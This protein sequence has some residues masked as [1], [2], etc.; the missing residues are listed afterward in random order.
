MN[1]SLA[2]IETISIPKGIEAGDA[3]M[4]ASAVD[5][6]AA[7]TVC[8]GKFIVIVTGDVAAVKASMEAGAE[9]AGQ[10]L[11]DSM[12]IPNIDPQVPLAINCCT[13]PHREDSIGILE[14]FSL[15]AAVLMA[16]TAVK[17]ADVHLTEV[18]L[19]RGLG[20]KSFVIFTGDVAAA[21]ASVKA[22][23]EVE[24]VQGLVSQSVVI[25]SV[26]PDIMKAIL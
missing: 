3:M 20:G 18:R 10:T 26:H 19:G 16:D 13:E 6:A 23:V 9:T 1:H 22:A 2:M 17:A 4:K 5:L 12:M 24:E 21:R 11:V 25:P 8:A 14:T 7:Q 15:C